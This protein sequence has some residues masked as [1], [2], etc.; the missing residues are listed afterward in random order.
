MNTKRIPGGRGC[1]ET[2]LS[3]RH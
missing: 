1:P 3:L 2:S